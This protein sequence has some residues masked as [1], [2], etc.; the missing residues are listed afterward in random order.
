MVVGDIED[1]ADEDDVRV[2]ACVMSCLSFAWRDI[3]VRLLQVIENQYP[4]R[5][6]GS[7]K[8]VQNARVGG[9]YSVRK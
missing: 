6:Q 1:I 2:S 9:G 3:K 8:R 7:S 4:P 5:K